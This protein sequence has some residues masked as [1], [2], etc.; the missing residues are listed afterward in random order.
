L[1]SQ[2]PDDRYGAIEQKFYRFENHQR[3]GSDGDPSFSDNNSLQRFEFSFLRK[4]LNDG[5]HLFDIPD[6]LS[7]ASLFDECVCQSRSTCI[8]VL[9]FGLSTDGNG[10]AITFDDPATDSAISSVSFVRCH[11]AISGGACWLRSHGFRI[12]DCCAI[13]CSRG[14]TGQFCVLSGAEN[15]PPLSNWVVLN[16]MAYTAVDDG[17]VYYSSPRETHALIALRDSDWHRR[18]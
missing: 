16:A 7:L 1:T 11:P 9:F 14:I 2:K 10:G 6:P 15:N 8:N 12:G 17:A 4:R 3:C 5:C 18:S 13:R